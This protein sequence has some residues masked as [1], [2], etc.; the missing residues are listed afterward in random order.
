[1]EPEELSFF[2]KK[3]AMPGNDG[4]SAI[5][6]RCIELVLLGVMLSGQ[7]QVL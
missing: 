2:S 6:T 4:I 7:V 1:M 3:V 5:N